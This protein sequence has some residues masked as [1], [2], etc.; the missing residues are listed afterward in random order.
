L[1]VVY[2]VD[3][4]NKQKEKTKQMKEIKKKLV[5]SRKVF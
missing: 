5:C 3:K 4:E 1:K 2:V